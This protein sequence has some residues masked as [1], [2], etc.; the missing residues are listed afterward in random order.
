MSTW[1][2]PAGIYFRGS[3]WNDGHD[4]CYYCFLGLITIAS[5]LGLNLLAPRKKI[6]I[7]LLGNHSA[8]KSSFINWY[9]TQ[10]FIS[11]LKYQFLLC[12][13]YISYNFSIK[14][15]CKIEQ[16]Q[17]WWFFFLLPFCL[18]NVFMSQGETLFDNSCL[19]WKEVEIMDD[20]Y[21]FS[22]LT[23]FWQPPLRVMLK[24]N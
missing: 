13:L 16:L 15:W 19:H 11:R 17:S 3:P 23:W 8:G 18:I 2:S 7:L 4:F 21:S 12:L 24:W 9:V 1:T 10:Q 5:G 20:L 22:L 6:T 14:I